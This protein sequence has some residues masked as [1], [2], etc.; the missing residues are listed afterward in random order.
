[1]IW[2]PWT[3]S[4][5]VSVEFPAI[6]FNRCQISASELCSIEVNLYQNC[7]YIHTLPPSGALL[8]DDVT[9]QQRTVVNTYLAICASCVMGMVTS[10]LIHGK[11]SMVSTRA[12]CGRITELHSQPLSTL[13]V[14]GFI[15]QNRRDSESGTSSENEWS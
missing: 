1:M 8:Y 13:H 9:V 7:V 2:W 6:C 4:L 5:Y 3:A 11:F 10:N 15:V 14:Y 12:D